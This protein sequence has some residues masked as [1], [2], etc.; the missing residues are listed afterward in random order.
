MAKET[1]DELLSDYVREI[2]L[3]LRAQFEVIQD[4][5]W[6]ERQDALELAVLHGTIS[7]RAIRF[8]E[9]LNEASEGDE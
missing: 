9:L 8:L 4:K 3:T 7:D 5:A 6:L 1:V 2:M